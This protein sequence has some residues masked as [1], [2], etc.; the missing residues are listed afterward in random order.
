MQRVE[1]RAL[2]LPNGGYRVLKLLFGG[3][4]FFAALCTLH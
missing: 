1:V 3:S 2:A 4:V